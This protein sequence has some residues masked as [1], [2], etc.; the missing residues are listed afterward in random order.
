[1]IAPAIYQCV[2]SLRERLPF[3]PLGAWPTPVHALP[4]TLGADLWVKRDDLSNPRYGGNKVRTL[5]AVLGDALARGATSI[6]ATGAFGSNHTLATAIHAPTFGLSVG[7]L[8][9][10]QPP[11]APAIANALALAATD[12]KMIALPSVAALPA[13]MM[14]TQLRHR[15]AVVMEPGA[16]T[17]VGACGAL[18]AALEL[19]LQVQRGELPLPASIVLPIGS[20]C[21]TAGLLAGCHLATTLGLWRA[22]PTIIGVRVTPWPVTSAWRIHRLARRALARVAVAAGRNFSIDARALRAGLVIDGGQLGAGYG[23]PTRSGRAA[24]AAFAQCEGVPI[25]DEVYASK[26]AAALATAGPRPTL[27]WSTK[28]AAPLAVP[29][30]AQRARMPRAMRA[31]LASR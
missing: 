17:A 27:F 24:I 19:A 10:P 30:D 3:A 25:L 28:S 26:A 11:S 8:L 21:T 12:I 5:E 4:S 23:L 15:G 13:A 2:P 1:M 18:S 7:A 6:W 16:A 22:A 20:N 29:T 31:W 14:I 9:F